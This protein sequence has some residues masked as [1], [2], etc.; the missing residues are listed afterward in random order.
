M[1]KHVTRMSG[2]ALL[3]RCVSLAPSLTS[4]CRTRWKP[5][6]RTPR[7]PSSVVMRLCPLLPWAAWR[8]STPTLQAS[9]LLRTPKAMMWLEWRMG[10][11]REGG[12]ACTRRSLRAS[13]CSTHN[14]AGRHSVSWRAGEGGVRSHEP[15]SRGLHGHRSKARGAT[16]VT[17]TC[18]PQ[19]RHSA[20]TLTVDELPFESMA[21]TS[22]LTLQGFFP[23][24]PSQERGADPDAGLAGDCSRA[25]AP[26]YA[27]SLL[28]P[29]CSGRC[30]TNS[31]II[32]GE[33]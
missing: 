12:R 5:P 27:L 8:T 13:A 3:S 17:G 11:Q 4:G 2:S 23:F 9:A 16:S 25:M 10:A 19:L 7:R 33:D 1:T 18:A 21:S 20:G 6:R 22:R 24:V 31:L 14:S 30:G 26:V 29:F 15:R 28:T 32:I